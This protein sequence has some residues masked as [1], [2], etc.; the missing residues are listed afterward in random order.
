TSNGFDNASIIVKAPYS[1]YGASLTL[2][3]PTDVPSTASS[4]DVQLIGLPGAPTGGTFTLTFQ[5]WTTAPI[6]FNA[7]PAQVHFA[8]AQIPSIGAG[9]IYVDQTKTKPFPIWRVMFIPNPSDP[10]GAI[11]LGN[12]PGDITLRLTGDGTNLTGGKN[13]TVV[14]QDATRSVD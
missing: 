4:N 11:S 14:T 6:P 9:S 3:A 12:R 13:N 7:T 5:G 8:L 10:P 1:N 2:V